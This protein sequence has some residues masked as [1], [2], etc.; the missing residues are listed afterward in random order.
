LRYKVAREEQDTQ[1]S[2]GAQIFKKSSAI[3]IWLPQREAGS[4]GFCNIPL[5]QQTNHLIV[6]TIF[7]LTADERDY[8]RPPQQL[9]SK[10]EFFS[11]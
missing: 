5:G 9:Q 3:Q 2:L 6:S 4:Q 10:N 1:F 11:D 7:V 8:G